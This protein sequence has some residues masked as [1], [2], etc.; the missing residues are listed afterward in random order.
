LLTIIRHLTSLIAPIVVC[1]VL[2]YFIILGERGSPSSSP[3]LFISGLVIGLS[4]LVLLIV[5]IRMFILIGGGTIMPWDPTRKMIIAGPYRYVRNPMILG[6]I[7]VAV[8]EAIFF[9]SYGIAL[10][11]AL[12]F[13]TNTVYFILSEEPGLEKRFG[14]EYVEYKKNVPRWIPRLPRSKQVGEP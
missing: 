3:W 1:C 2:P 12:F 7:G 11:A 10:L 9:A 8:G 4:G 14:A 5:T 6:V 13:V